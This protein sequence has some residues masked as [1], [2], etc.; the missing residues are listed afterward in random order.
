Q[1]FAFADSSVTLQNNNK[2]VL[3]YAYAEESTCAAPVS[4][5]PQL[6]PRPKPTGNNSEKRLKFKTKI[7]EGKL[8]LFDSLVLN[9]E[10]PLKDL[11]TSLIHFSSDSFFAPIT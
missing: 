10:Q 4:S 3:L 5:R 9:F 7:K 2:P 8:D 6:A 1:L 11:D